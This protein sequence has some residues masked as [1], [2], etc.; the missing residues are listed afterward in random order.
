MPGN[1]CF[2]DDYYS[3]I[4]EQGPNGRFRH[5]TDLLERPHAQRLFAVLPKV[6]FSAL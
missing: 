2:P 1:P 5:S 6:Q 3:G 4:E